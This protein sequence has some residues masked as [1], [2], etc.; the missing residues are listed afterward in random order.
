MARAVAILASYSCLY[1]L[2]MGLSPAKDGRLVVRMGDEKKRMRDEWVM[3]KMDNDD[4]EM[5]NI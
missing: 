3:E 1:P 4:G 5:V 2:V